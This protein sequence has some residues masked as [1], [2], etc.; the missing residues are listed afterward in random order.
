MQPDPK[1]RNPAGQGG[2]T[3]QANFNISDSAISATKRQAADALA[4][5][6]FGHGFLVVREPI[7]ERFRGR[8][9]SRIRAWRAPI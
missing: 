3:S 2:A 4:R 7:G 6:V 8:A 5:Q 9:P 1:M